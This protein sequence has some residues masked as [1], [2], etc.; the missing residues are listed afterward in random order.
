[1][2]DLSYEKV[3]LVVEIWDKVKSKSREFGM[4]VMENLFKIQ[5]K[6][7]KVF[8]YEKGEDVGCMNAAVHAVSIVGIIDQIIGMLG[9]DK[10][11]LSFQ[12]KKL[13]SS[14]SR[15][16]ISHSYIYLMGN[17]ILSALKEFSILQTNEEED[18][19]L[20]VFEIIS[21]EMILGMT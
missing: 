16:G 2:N 4:T 11:F 13:G 18:T 12:L 6:C 17:A 19:W 3:F 9:P 7:K 20:E 1:M 5:P 10:D 14:H 21:N 8:G 15:M